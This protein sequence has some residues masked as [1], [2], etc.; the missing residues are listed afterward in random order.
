MGGRVVTARDALARAAALGVELRLEAGGQVRI[1]A[2]APPPADLLAELRRWRDEV[3][4]LLADR[5]RPAWSDAAPQPARRVYQ[6][7]DPDPLRDG[8]LV[9]AR[10]HLPPLPS[11]ARGTG[12]T[13]ADGEQ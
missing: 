1:T 3:V 7:G 10:R 2:D 13:C 9:S 6:P 8:L 12:V 4:R 5:R 11:A